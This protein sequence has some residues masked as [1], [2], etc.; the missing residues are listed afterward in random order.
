MFFGSMA[1]VISRGA[2]DFDVKLEDGVIG[3]VVSGDGGVRAHAG[4]FLGCG[5]VA[6]V[7]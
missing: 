7:C 2:T 3:G 5:F 4:A 1:L 6:G